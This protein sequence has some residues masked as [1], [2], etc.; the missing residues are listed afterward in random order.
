MRTRPMATLLLLLTL[1]SAG[2]DEVEAPLVDRPVDVPFSEAIARFVLDPAGGE[3]VAPFRIEADVRPR[4]LEPLTATTLTV[5]VH[6]RGPVLRPPVRPDLRQMAA[7]AATFHVE[8]WTDGRPARVGASVYRWEYRL[9]PKGDSVGEVPGVPFLF[10][11]P[12][13]RPP[14]KGYQTLWTDPIPLTVRRPERPVDV[15][16]LP[17][18]VLEWPDGDLLARQ[19]RWAPPGAGVVAAVLL[20]PPLLAVAFYLLW[21]QRHPDAARAAHRRRSRAA[22]VALRQLDRARRWRG[23]TEAEAAAAALTD[24]LGDRFGL[25]RVEPTPAEAEALLPGHGCPADLA[26]A[27]AAL[28]AQIAAARFQP[29]EPSPAVLVG[30]VRHFVLA[31]EERT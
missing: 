26:S 21:R 4:E 13:V 29:A 20:V 10:Y 19:T 2:A 16:S 27:A 28:L 23:R 6:A 12:D 3:L 31:V 22:R 25:M 30:A 15:S 7:F 18:A 14:A 17:P 11:N 9:R 1:S 24:Y 8:D 5:T